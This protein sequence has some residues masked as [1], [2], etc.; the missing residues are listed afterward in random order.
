MRE[1][2]LELDNWE[3]P[4]TRYN[5]EQSGNYRLSKSSYPEGYYKHYCM[6][7]YAYTKVLKPIPI[8]LLQEYRDGWRDWMADDPM[9]YRAMQKYAEAAYGDVLVA[10]LGLGLVLYELNKNPRVK[11]ITVVERSPDVIN[12]TGKYIPDVTLVNADFWDFVERD[13]GEWDFIIVDI[14]ATKGKKEHDRVYREQV[15]PRNEYL[16]EKYNSLFVFHG[17]NEITD[18]QI[19]EPFLSKK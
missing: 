5:E 16:R 19:I 7:G 6:D 2:V 4:A 9:D 14:W 3:T 12:L 10:G 18:V 1:L 17:F 15:L 11:S 8:T 13:G